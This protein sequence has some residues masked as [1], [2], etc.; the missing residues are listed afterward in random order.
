MVRP[1]LKRLNLWQRH[2]SRV[3]EV[4][5]MALRLLAREN[6]LPVGENALNRRLYFCILRAL[7]ELHKQGVDLITYPVY[8]GNNQ[9]DA[10]DEDRVTREDKRPDFQFGFID[11][12]EPDPDASARQYVIECKR[13][14]ESG[15]ADWVLNLNYV[16]H[17]VVRFRDEEHGYGKSRVSGAMIGYVQNSALEQVLDGVNQAASAGGL[18]AI[19]LSPEGWRRGDVSRL[20]HRF[21]RQIQPT[22]FLLRHLWLEMESQHEN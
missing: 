20:D 18:T 6:N 19:L 3:L 14:G 21:C 9:P 12:Q 5:A 15:R 2:E 7:R 4:L 22:S 10:S 13:L 8:E 11:H 1:T 16:A 17:G